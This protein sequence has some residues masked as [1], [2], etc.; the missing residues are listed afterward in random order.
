ML[1]H[2]IEK[3]T[4]LALEQAICLDVV[5]APSHVVKDRVLARALKGDLDNII[6]R[7]MQKEPGRRYEAVEHLAED[8][9][10]YLE[11]RP[12]SAQPDSP[13]YRIGKFVRR[14]RAV[15][16]VSSLAIGAVLV[17]ELA[18]AREA[19]IANQRFEDVRK[20]A[21][22]FV[23]DVQDAAANLP[24]ALGIRKLIVRTGVEYLNNLARDSS[25]DWDLK[26]E[27][28][29]AYLRIGTIQGGAQSSNLGDSDSAFTNF[30][31]AG[32]LLDE[33]IRHNP[34]DRKAVIERMA[35]YSSM[36]NLMRQLGKNDAATAATESAVRIGDGWMASFPQ[37]PEVA[38]QAG[39]AHLD[40][41][42]LRQ[43][44][45]DL[46][47]AETEAAVGTSLMLRMAAAL[48][49]DKAQ[50][51]LAESHAR[52]GSVKAALGRRDE[53]LASYG[54]QVAVLETL[55]RSRPNDTQARHELMLAYSHIGDN[56]G[57]YDYDN[58]GDL[59][60]AFRA[61]S[62]MAEL[63]KYLYDVDPLDARAMADYGIALL[64]LGIA[65]PIGGPAKRKTLEQSQEKLGQVLRLDPHNRTAAFHEAWVEYEL[66]SLS[67]KEGD[68]ASGVRHYRAALGTAE[69]VLAASPDNSAMHR[70]YIYTVRALAEVQAHNAQR[71]EALATLERGL[72]VSRKANASSR[73]VPRIKSINAARA[74]QTAGCRGNL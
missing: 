11:H 45:G 48:P 1:P 55:S 17:G 2:R 33:V 73:A 62:K 70:H 29:A 9:R 54:S 23:F 53:A 50:L 14:N 36:S 12:V 40:L 67:I 32:S 3:C 57:N 34:A 20:L 16:S 58:A 7:A 30:G 44:S 22:T 21:T 74:A 71:P 41:A 6:G 46:D 63:A 24:G 51:E 8:L 18:T 61:Y 26:R 27:L 19:R 64:R 10:R 72:A 56:L 68:R 13:A 35:V 69:M 37:D 47:R 38:E 66:G 43:Q 59:P 15:V 5:P 25:R 49:G 60:G 31:K 65:T 52:L 42:R 28:G 4:P 39:I